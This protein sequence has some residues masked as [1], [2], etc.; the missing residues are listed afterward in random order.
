MADLGHR[1]EVGQ[2]ESRNLGDPGRKLSLCWV[3][4][5]K[6]GYRGLG[7]FQEGLWWV[8]LPLTLSK[9]RDVKPMRG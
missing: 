2:T 9:S 8:W 1:G 5:R 3:P 6:A 4:W 7:L